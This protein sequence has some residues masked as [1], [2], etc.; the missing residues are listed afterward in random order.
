MFNI[1]S[2]DV[3]FNSSIRHLVQHL[4]LP[5][6]VSVVDLQCATYYKVPG[7]RFHFLIN[8]F[9]MHK[10]M[11]SF[12]MNK[13]LYCFVSK[14]RSL[15]IGHIIDHVTDGIPV[16]EQIH[17]TRHERDF[18]CFLQTDLPVNDYAE[19]MGVTH[20]LV[21]NHKRGLM[22]KLGFESAHALYLMAKYMRAVRAAIPP[23]EDNKKNT[24]KLYC[25]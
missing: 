6:S 17:L 24:V 8:S 9:P 14:G 21:S 22:K 5:H 2:H 7:A 10:G 4:K 23:Q 20:K 3:F 15:A 11:V 13:Q 16:G 12:T 19:V 18:L 25:S 1:F